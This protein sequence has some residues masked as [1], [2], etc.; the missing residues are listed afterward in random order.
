MTEGTRPL[1]S[2][3]IANYNGERLLPECIASVQ[4]QQGDFDVEIIIHDDASNDASLAVLAG[5]P[6]IRLIKSTSNV[7]FCLANNR[8]V[9]QARGRHVLLLNNDAALFPDAIST[10]LRE[11]S[12][13]GPSKILSLPQYDWETGDLVDR[14]CLLDLLHVPVPNLDPQ[15]TQVAYVI[16]A[17][18]WVARIDWQRVG[19]FPEWM[20]SIGEDIFLCAKARL[21]G[22]E[23]TVAP[24]SGYRHRQGASFGGNRSNGIRLSTNLRRRRLSERNRAAVLAVCTPGFALLIWMTFHI[25]TLV[26]EACMICLLKRSATPWRDVYGATL[27][28][29]WRQRDLL[30]HVRGEVQ[31]TRRICLANYVRYAYTWR[32]R[33][34]GMLIRHGLPELPL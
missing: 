16:G 3:C 18:L 15:R 20:E 13:P 23:V 34:L 25:V 14:G 10:L 33:K 32:L 11:A 31:G 22:M 5:Y 28:W 27:K 29:L 17:C 8:M 21:S 6:E 4:A 19:G 26:I 9:E 12:L 30:R 24:T 2:V 7:G 1:V